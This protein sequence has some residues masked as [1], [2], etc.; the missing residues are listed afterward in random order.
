MSSCFITT[1]E[2]SLVSP[3]ASKGQCD[4]SQIV[5]TYLNPSPKQRPPPPAVGGPEASVICR[6]ATTGDSETNVPRGDNSFYRRST[7][8]K[9]RG[10][11]PVMI[12][13]VLVC[14]WVGAGLTLR[15]KGFLF[16]QSET[17]S[18][19]TNDTDTKHV[20]SRKKVS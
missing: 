18:Q 1:R 7:K 15:G 11:R 6:S 13:R 4:T 17:C 14:V 2:E 12:H 5:V 3:P 16:I 10:Y 9:G 8:S 19:Y 20:K